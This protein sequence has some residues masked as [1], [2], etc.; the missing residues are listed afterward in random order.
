MG[1]ILNR[2]LFC[3]IKMKLTSLLCFLFLLPFLCKGQIDTT[4]IKTYKQKL[5]IRIFS[6]KDLML[7]TQESP[8]GEDKTYI[9]NNPVKIGLG[10]SI[11][12]TI[13]NLKMGYGFDF[14]R[15]KEYGKTKSFDFQ[16]HNYSR[17][18]A[19]DLFIQRYKG[20]Y[21]EDESIR[22]IRLYPDLEMKQLGVSAQYIF[23]YNKFSYKAAFQQGER[24]AKSAGS[25]LAGI[26][27]YQ[28][29]IKS[30][31]SFLHNGRNSLDNFQFG[32]SGGYAYTWVLGTKWAL[33]ASSTVGINFGSEHLSRFGKQKLE[34]YPNVFPRLAAVYNRERWALSVSVVSNI[35]FPSMV[36]QSQLSLVSGSA[37][38]TYVRRLDSFPL[39]DKVLNFL[40]L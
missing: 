36:D 26:G 7:L 3:Y 2:C 27:I 8:S 24:Q 4:Y 35:L 13:L 38:V 29:Q 23:N 11:R 9:P 19:L 22:P 20:F 40:H 39:L 32:I 1:S 21:D 17:R 12:N 33:T 15:D 31:S 14:M 28:T 25:I 30:D 6:A 37:E 5:A 10:L 34:I 18:L 16:L